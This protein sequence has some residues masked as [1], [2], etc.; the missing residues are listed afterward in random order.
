[1]ATKIGQVAQELARTNPWWRDPEWAAKDP[2]LRK[3]LD[4]NL[5]YRSP[6]LEGLIEGGLYLLRGPRR[7]GKTVTVKQTIQDLIGRGIPPQ[8]I[9]RIAADAWSADDIRTV[10]QNMALL[11]QQV[12]IF[13]SNLDVQIQGHAGFS[14]SWEIE[15]ESDYFSGIPLNLSDGS[16]RGVGTFNGQGSSRPSAIIFSPHFDVMDIHV[17]RNHPFPRTEARSLWIFATKTVPMSLL[18]WFGTVICAE[19]P[20]PRVHHIV[21]STG[22]QIRTSITS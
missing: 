9:I 18:P 13:S 7:V 10:V 11:D 20:R 17:H 6:C 22:T 15:Y 12:E 4:A 2:D 21:A 3:V 5:G 19:A 1:V 8:S 16:S 14:A